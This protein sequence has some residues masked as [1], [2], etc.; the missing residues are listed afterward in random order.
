MYV[1]T[2]SH[3]LFIA[4]SSCAKDRSFVYFILLNKALTW[5]QNCR[6]SSQIDHTEYEHKIKVLV[7]STLR[8]SLMFLF[9]TKNN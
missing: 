6:E 4:L 8:C 9:V 1:L 7:M 2:K 3:Y 5:D